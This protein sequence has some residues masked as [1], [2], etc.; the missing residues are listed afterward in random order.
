MQKKLQSNYYKKAFYQT[1]NLNNFHLSFNF[2]ALISDFKVA[3][4]LKKT[5]SYAIYHIIKS[6]Y[7]FSINHKLHTSRIYTD[8]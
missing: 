1:F 8:Y 5:R 3:F 7:A 4:K 2:K 6:L